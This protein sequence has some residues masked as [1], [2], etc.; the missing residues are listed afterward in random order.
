MR[1][2]PDPSRVYRI[3]ISVTV[4]DHSADRTFKRP[5]LALFAKE[6]RLNCPLPGLPALSTS[7]RLLAPDLPDTTTPP[8]SPHPLPRTLFRHEPA[9]ARHGLLRQV[10]GNSL[11]G[12]RSVVPGSAVPAL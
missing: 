10:M 1:P 7:S 8:E 9:R 12:V 2:L 3:W 11:S 4:G 5:A 6:G